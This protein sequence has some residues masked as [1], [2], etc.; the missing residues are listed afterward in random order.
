MV[1]PFVSKGSRK[2][3]MNH[4]RFMAVMNRMRFMASMDG[5]SFDIMSEKSVEEQISST[6]D[7]FYFLR[8]NTAV[9]H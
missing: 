8:G 9:V 5:H 4:M 2:P 6:E 1:L 7:L 3:S